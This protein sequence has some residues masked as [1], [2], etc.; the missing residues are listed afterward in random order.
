[1]EQPSVHEFRSTL[2]RK[3]RRRRRTI[4]K[5]LQELKRQFIDAQEWHTWER[6]GLVL[7]AYLYEIVKGARQ[8]TLSDWETDKELTID[9]DPLLLPSD[10]IM[11]MIKR[12]KKFKAALPHLQQQLNLTEANLHKIDLAIIEAENAV[13]EEILHKIEAA[14][15]LATP[16]KT[17]KPEKVPSLPYKEYYTENGA[18]IWVGKGAKGNDQLTFTFANGL[19]WWFHADAYSGAHVVVRQKGELDAATINEA[20]QL[21][22]G[23]SKAPKVGKVEVVMTQV[24]H[25][26]KFK[27]AK[28]GAVHVSKHKKVLGEFNKELYDLILRRLP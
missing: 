19:D 18:I 6:K 22:I 5:R 24:K 7:Q 23:Q 3:L 27:G 28:A 8:V 12:S 16:V 15:H 4:A 26:K 20:L 11:K 2:L 14:F 10:Q 13:S 21:A 1:M 25:V 9:L 17:D